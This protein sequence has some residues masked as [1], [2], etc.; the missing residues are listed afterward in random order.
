MAY[1][2]YAKKVKGRKVAKIFLFAISTCGWCARVKALLNRLGVEYSYVDVDLLDESSQE[3][4]QKELKDRGA[5][6]LFPKTIINKKIINGFDE[7]R[8]L[9]A[10]K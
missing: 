7:R 3:E 5:D 8:I 2:N 4:I 6:F 10:L 1:L 9:E